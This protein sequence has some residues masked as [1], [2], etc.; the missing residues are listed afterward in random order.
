MPD[1][2]II[3]FLLDH[4]KEQS[5]IYCS[6]D[7]TL[8]RRKYR[9]EHPTEFAAL[10]CMDGRINLPIITKTPWGIIQPF[11][12]VGGKFDFGWPYFGQ[13]IQ[14]WVSYSVSRGRDCI[15]LITYHWSKGSLH[16]GCKGFNYS[17]SESQVHTFWLKEQAERIYG[18]HHSVVYPIQVGVE[19]DE[20]AL[21]IHGKNGAVL[22]LSTLK[23]GETTDK[24]M[25]VMIEQLFPDMNKRMVNDF[26]PILLGNLCHIAEIRE[27]KRPIKEVEHGEDTIALGRGFSWLHIPN[28]A[29]IVGPFSYVLSEPIATAANIVLSNLTEGRVHKKDGA[30]LMVSALCREPA[31]PEKLAAMEKADSLARLA[32]D[33]IKRKVPKLM[34]YLKVLVG[35]VN[36]NTMLFTP[37]EKLEGLIKN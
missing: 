18:K 16:R 15:I 14:D 20:D 27:A 19:T 23:N 36:N 34:P 5:R 12:N 2:K 25:R 32:M 24:T 17:V 30:V 21:F 11:R 31:G 8:A 37:N 7:E 22:D 3:K 4:N 13:L 10:K 35:T 9:A 33:T 1:S 28:K 29:L 26:I 6:P